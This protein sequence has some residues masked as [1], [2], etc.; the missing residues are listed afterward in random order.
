MKKYT[1]RLS[2]KQI[3]F[4][5]SLPNASQWLRDQ[6]RKGML[7]MEEKP[8]QKII[9]WNRRLVQLEWKIESVTQ[10]GR[11]KQA[12]DFLEKLETTR[13][14]IEACKAVLEDLPHVNVQF[15]RGMNGRGVHVMSL[16]NY[17]RK[18]VIPFS[19]WHIV[20]GSQEETVRKALNENLEALNNQL[21]RLQREEDRYRKVKESYEKLLSEL[22][23]ETEQLKRK[24][25]EA[26]P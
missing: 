12:E 17:D 9:A 4:L 22:W 3:E 16:K 21:D 10:D 5:R 8:H 15:V 6:I 23:K 24:I 18:V 14:E 20:E 25:E 1:V 26:S 19:M 11:F 2:E 7:E 13:K